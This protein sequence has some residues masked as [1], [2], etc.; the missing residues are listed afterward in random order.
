MR[1]DSITRAVTHPFEGGY[2]G[3]VVK[4]KPQPTPDGRYLAIGI[5]CCGLDT[6][7]TLISLTPDLPSFATQAEAATVG[8][9][10]ATQWINKNSLGEFANDTKKF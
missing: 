6:L 9:E 5:V 8:W 10:A 3:Y 4:Y 2:G 7:H 1:R